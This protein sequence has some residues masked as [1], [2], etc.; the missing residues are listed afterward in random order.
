[1]NARSPDEG[2]LPA[3]IPS[4]GAALAS[5]LTLAC[6]LPVGILAGFGLA[7]AAVFLAEARTWLLVMSAGLL[8]WSFYQLRR[9]WQCGA[10]PSVVNL[11]LLGLATVI[12]VFV[13]LFPQVIAG[14]LA[15]WGGGSR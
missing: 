10:R 4:V 6:C 1:V 9:G 12:V 11:V 14:W 8:G 3:A 2:K 15:D 7:G 5:L 13:L